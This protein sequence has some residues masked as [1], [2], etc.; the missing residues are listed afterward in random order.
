MTI[1][2]SEAD[3]IRRVAKAVI[4]GQSLRSLALELNERGVKTVKGSRW[5]SNY[6]S[7]MLK[8]PRLAGLREHQAKVIGTACWPA[9][10]DRE[11]WEA[12]KAILDDPGRR[13]GGSGRGPSPTALGT[14][15]CRCGGATPPYDWDLPMPRRPVYKCGNVETDASWAM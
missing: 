8:R 2:E 11:T 15:L 5:V 10:L 3:E 13:S 6:L 9:I 7:K 1:R 14:G 12:V 4:A